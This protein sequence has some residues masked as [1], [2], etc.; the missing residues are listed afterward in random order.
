[1]HHH[2]HHAHPWSGQWGG[3]LPW[4]RFGDFSRS[5]VQVVQPVIEVPDWAIYGGLG[6]LA[7]L[8]FRGVH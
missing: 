6:L 8:A 7:I 3:Y 1:M 2:G 5:Q 4:N